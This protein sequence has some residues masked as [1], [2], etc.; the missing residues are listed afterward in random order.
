MK[1]SLFANV[2]KDTNGAFIKKVNLLT[3]KLCIV[4]LLQ[5]AVALILKK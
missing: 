4:R 2:N 5:K 3:V 1:F